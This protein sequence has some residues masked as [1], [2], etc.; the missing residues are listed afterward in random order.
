MPKTKSASISKAAFVRSLPA[1]TPAKEVTAK[2]KSAGLTISEAYVYNVR[3]TSKP[4][5][6]GQ[7]RGASPSRAN[8][9]GHGAE[10]LLRA[11]AAEIGLSRALSILQA[12]R[13]S[14]RALL[15]A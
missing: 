4:K 2:A 15:R 9:S 7:R 14:V 10:E 1:S 5:K 6:N 11:L 12:Q 13:D 8:G 3:A